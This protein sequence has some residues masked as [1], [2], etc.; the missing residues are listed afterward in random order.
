[1]TRRRLHWNPH[2]ALGVAI[3]LAFALLIGGL[4]GG[5]AA[6]AQA[7]PQPAATPAPPVQPSPPTAE[8]AATQPAPVRTPFPAYRSQLPALPTLRTIFAAG[9]AARP[10]VT[11]EPEESPLDMA[12]ESPLATPVTD[13]I[14]P[15]IQPDADLGSLLPTPTPTPIAIADMLAQPLPAATAPET[16]AL[17]PSPTAAPTES[18]PP[19]PTLEPTPDGTGRTARVPILMYHYLSVPPA[20]ANIYRQD[21][22][23]SPDLFATHLDAMQQAG[24]TSISLYDLLAHLTRGAPLPEKPVVITFDDGY[25]DNYENAFPLLQQRGMVASFFVVTDFVDEQRPEYF[26]WDMLREMA[27]A[28][29]SIES[30]GRNHVSLEGKNADYLVWQALGSLETIQHELGVRPRFVSY[31]AGEYDQAVIDIFRSANF[32]AGLT[33][34]QG[35]THSSDDLFQLHRVRVRGTTTPDELLRL[36]AL[37]W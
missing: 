3:A 4:L 10:P 16:A 27:A 33:T 21:L 32:W 15:A 31:P 19:A 18:A 22:S 1:M 23:V 8:P 30:H 37:D 6:S 28:G 36:L 29:M 25:R 13:A 14:Q 12:L 26:T 35:A 11:V 9:V 20:N 34:K 24:Y 2:S 7:K 5:Y 17:L